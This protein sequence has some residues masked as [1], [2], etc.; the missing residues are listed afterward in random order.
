MSMVNGSSVAG[1][2][3]SSPTPPASQSTT[4]RLT[5]ASARPSA[6]VIGGGLAGISAAVSLADRGWRV[7][8]IEARPRLGGAA[9]SF[10]RGG[11]TVDTGAHVVLRCYTAYRTLLARMGVAENLPV[12]SRMSI[13]VLGRAMRA[14]PPRPARLRRGRFGP[15]P[16]HLLPALAG[17]RELSLPERIRAV[18]A[19]LAL[20]R[21]DPD[22]PSL[23]REPFGRWLSRHGQ[24]E[25]AIEALWGLLCVAALNIV[26]AEAST[27]LMTRVLRTGLLDHPQAGD[28]G[29]PAVP[30][31]A[32][33]DGPARGL[34]RRLGV[35]CRTGQKVGSITRSGS[36]YAIGTPVA[37]L[38]VDAVVVAVPHRQAAVLVP[39][40]AAPDG[41]RWSALGSSP[42]VNVH[43]HLDRIVTGDALPP[44]GFAAVLDSPLQ[45]VFDRTAAAGTT[46]QY[47]VSSVSAADSAV[48]RPAADLL[49]AARTEIELLFP[50][51]RSAVLLDGFVTREPHA[52][53]RQRAGSGSLRPAVA[54]RWPGLALAGSWTA[55]GLP[56]TLEGAVRSGQ[57]AAQAIAAA[58]PASAVTDE[59]DRRGGTF[60]P[61]RPRG[62][63]QMEVM[64]P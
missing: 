21:L 48:G 40:G 61:Y 37:D 1:A 63:A 4:T 17:Y 51:A 44:N 56:D 36:G 35:D 3:Q 34:L 26:P 27:A 33:H 20:S 49:S 5:T 38:A 7:T 30:L 60:T 18:R 39:H 46:G 59:T 31:S 64:T 52:T 11:L 12:Q 42:I 9:Y 50:A 53:F 45:W 54:T 57:L 10:D 22:D 58:G 32:L 15:A 6:A 24:D 55:T 28:V 43:L 19:A 29:V 41:E 2:T 14:N 47:L 23:D 8:L 13:P 16:L 62:E 25:H